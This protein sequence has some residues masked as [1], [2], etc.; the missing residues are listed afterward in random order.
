MKVVFIH[1]LG[2]GDPEGAWL[3]GLNRGL[4][5]AGHPP[6]DTRDVVAPRYP[7]LLSTLNISAKL[8][9][10]TYKPKDDASDRVAFERR[11][12]KVQRFLGHQPGVNVFGFHRVPDA[13]VAF[14]QGAAINALPLKDLPHVKRYMQ[15]EGLRGAIL[16]HILDHLPTSGDI[17]LIGHSLGSVVAIDLL[18][19]LHAGLH[20]RRFITIGS[21]ANARAL[22]ENSD[23]LL[24]KF[25][26]GRVDDWS[27]F[28]SK[29]DVVTAGRGLAS[30]FQGA[31]DYAVDIGL[32]HD[33]AL[34]LEHQSVARLIGR[35]LYPNSVIARRTTGI[36]ARLSDNETTIL[37]SLRFAHT[38]QQHVKDKDAAARYASALT[39]QQDEVAAQVEADSVAGSS[40]I[41]PELVELANGTLPRLPHRWDLQEAVGRLVVLALTNLVD[42]YEINVDRAPRDALPDIAIEMGFLRS[43][44]TTIG[45]A[46]EDVQKHITRKGGLPWGRVLTAAVGVAIVAAGPVGLAL[47]APAGL[48]GAA[49]LT[50]GLAALGPGGMIGGLAMLGGLAGTGAAVAASAAA[51]GGGSVEPID[52][53]NALVLQVA[54]EHA[55][56][57][58]GL[59]HDENLWYRITELETQLSAR[60]NRLA[61]YSDPKSPKLET[62]RTDHHTV[63]QLLDFMIIKNLAPDIFV[64]AE[65]ESDRLIASERRKMESDKRIAVWE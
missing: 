1:G 50:S 7:S 5:Q 32:N 38:V 49:A 8:P 17:L 36:D 19:N 34:Y 47:A 40:A 24:R 43:S 2:D 13:P 44:G 63:A 57:L 21:P 62:L 41:A 30:T 6:I 56:K 3:E 39:T 26:Y 45:T 22:N 58:L 60:I 37:L 18:D 53:S 33:A 42:P 20:V 16:R 29:G 27:N 59:P 23:R 54:A 9:P 25:P 31:Q 52:D 4:V 46:I 65:A 48:F 61:V 15:E 51:V 55:R 12:A 14:L 10:V 28:F 35:S 64:T 11:Q